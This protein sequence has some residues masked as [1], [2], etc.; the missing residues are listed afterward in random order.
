MVWMMSNTA[1]PEEASTSKADHL[2][3]LP[4]EPP[5]HFKFPAHHDHMLSLAKICKESKQFADCIIQSDNGFKHRAHRLVLG[6]ASSFLKMI[7]QEVPQSLPEATV[8]V[9]GVKESTVKALLDF[10]YTGE[11]SVERE[12]TADLQLLI[13][14]LQINPNLITVDLVVD[15]NNDV[16]ED[17]KKRKHKSNEAQS[18]NVKSAGVKRKVDE[19]GDSEKEERDI[20][21]K[22]AKCGTDE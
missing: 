6:S 3:P 10:L 2:A 17:S 16:E 11:M 1:A 13:E 5:R 18:P 21:L 20:Q 22:K 12:D 19:G 4:S 7:F 9:P 14:T 15:S 8:L